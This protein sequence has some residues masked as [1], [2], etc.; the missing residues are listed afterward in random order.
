VECTDRKALV[1][2]FPFR[3]GVARSEA[4]ILIPEIR[5]PTNDAW[6]IVTSATKGLGYPI[7]LQA[8]YGKGTLYVLTI[9]DN[10]GDLYNL[11][12][13]VLTQIR[14]AVAGD[15]PVLLE[16]PSQIGLFTYDN[17]KFIVE[18]FGAPGGQPVA[19]RAV[20][21]R[22]SAKLV[23]I[24]TGQPVSGQARG[25]KMVFDLTLPPASYRVFS[26]E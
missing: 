5:Y 7:L 17:G 18:N 24:V 1:H 3:G 21:A 19:T 22:K 6:E 4:D 16:G 15:L 13:E 23:D 12:A 11:P 8:A 26:V 20:V 14:N 10:F 2:E 9:P 25:E